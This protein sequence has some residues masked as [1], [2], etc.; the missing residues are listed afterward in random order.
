[1][2]NE[3]FPYET[4]SFRLEYHDGNDHRICWFQCEEHLKKYLNT[5]KLKMSNALIEIP[6]EEK[7]LVKNPR[8]TTTKA[9]PVQQ[10]ATTKAKPVQQKAT[11]KKRAK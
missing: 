4:F 2:T 11:V 7:K 10:K 1:M 9:K 8:T 5:Y 3:R 6:G